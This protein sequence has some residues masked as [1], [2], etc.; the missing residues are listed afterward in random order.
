M[1]CR[2]SNQDTWKK[3]VQSQRTDKRNSKIQVFNYATF[4]NFKAVWT[5]LTSL[6]IALKFMNEWIPTPLL[7]EVT[8]SE[9][10]VDHRQFSRT[11]IVY[12]VLQDIDHLINR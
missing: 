10:T 3:I 4:E 8:L 1:Q 6:E 9:T 12:K 5:Y 2:L 7:R 11:P